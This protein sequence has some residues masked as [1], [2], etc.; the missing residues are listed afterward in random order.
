MM[1]TSAIEQGE[2][3]SM[4]SWEKDISADRVSD[5]GIIRRDSTSTTGSERPLPLG[6]WILPISGN[7]PRC[8]HH[9]KSVK[10]H[11]RN[12]NNSG[13][14]VDLHCEK[15]NKLWL[16]SGNRN[17]TRVSLASNETIDQPFIEP[18]IRTTLAH[19]VRAATRVGTLSPTLPNIT[20]GVAV[21]Y[22]FP[23]NFD[24]RVTAH[25][26]GGHGTGTIHRMIPN[27]TTTV[28]TPSTSGTRLRKREINAVNNNR[29]PRFILRL[30]R[31][32]GR[33]FPNLRTTRLGRLMKIREDS[34][35]SAIECSPEANPE[36][37]M[38][39]VTA[40]SQP[41]STQIPPTGTSDENCPKDGSKEMEDCVPPAI[42]T[43]GLNSR[44]VVDQEVINAMTPDQQIALLRSQI[45]AFSTRFNSAHGTTV[46]NFH[47]TG[48][49]EH[50]LETLAT[51]AAIHNSLLLTGTGNHFG[52]YHYLD[53]FQQPEPGL[54]HETL[55]ISDTRISEAPTVVDGQIFAPPGFVREALHRGIRLSGQIR[56][57]STQSNMQNWDQIR[58]DTGDI[59]SS[60]ESS[61]RHR[62]SY[63][64]SLQSMVP[65]SVLYNLETSASQPQLTTS[66]GNAADCDTSSPKHSST[67]Q[68]RRASE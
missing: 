20:E 22:H 29:P 30:H 40:T 54:A 56:P 37:I 32:L 16:G 17:S 41:M 14:M 60:F 5:I 23:D 39:L 61:I 55:S 65:P 18:E 58:R 21:P 67:Q 25:R 3:L 9:H 57:L 42:A 1:A 36:P 59:R 66:R 63:R 7:C 26:L 19:M 8:R 68:D 50:P 31:R 38:E 44:M 35:L 6:H 52:D 24:S 46:P 10:I 4:P 47:F 27:A 43:H 28:K 11:V 12:A 33:T 34:E 2:S 64:H 49:R 62:S 45:T 13:G 51:L 15:C 48:D 53:V